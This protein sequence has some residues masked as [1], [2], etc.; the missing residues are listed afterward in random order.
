[1][2]S[3]WLDRVAK[4]RAVPDTYTGPK[5]G[6]SYS[7]KTDEEK[8]SFG[9]VSLDCIC[10]EL[11]FWEYDYMVQREGEHPR[12]GGCARSKR[13]FEFI[14]MMDMKILHIE[15][16]F[17]QATDPKSWHS[18]NQDNDFLDCRLLSDMK[19]P[20]KKKILQAV[21]YFFSSLGNLDR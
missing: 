21:L 18:V 14:C 5:R 17:H 2:Y 8:D 3:E 7:E 13:W 11:E 16:F 19:L 10:D 20:V 12:K 6:A 15:C 4:T 9:M 1:M